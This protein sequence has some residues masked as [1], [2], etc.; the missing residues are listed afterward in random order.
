LVLVNL[1]FDHA[2]LFGLRQVWD[3]GRQPRP[4]VLLVLGP[5]RYVRHP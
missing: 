1:R 3:W 4:E 5:Y 2:G